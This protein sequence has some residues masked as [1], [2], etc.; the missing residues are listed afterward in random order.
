MLTLEQRLQRLEDIE[1]IRRLKA[2]YFHACD[3]KQLADIRDCFCNGEVLIDYGQLGVFTHRDELLVLFEEKA[4][5]DY[6]IDLH[7]GQNAQIEWHNESEASALWDLFFYQVDTSTNILTQ[8][9]GF[10]QDAFVKQNGEWRIRQTRFE[11]TSSYVCQVNEGQL[12]VL[13][14]GGKPQ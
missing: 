14:A 2:R 8:L 6:I 7:H 5:H 12:Q 1:A 11:V 3:R 13:F 4:C 10:Y 9:G